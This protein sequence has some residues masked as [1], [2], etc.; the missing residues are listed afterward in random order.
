[1]CASVDSSLLW[2]LAGRCSPLA[3]APSPMCCGTRCASCPQTQ[4]PPAKQNCRTA[5]NSRC[6]GA[7]PYSCILPPV[8]MCWGSLPRCKARTASAST[9]GSAN[10][11][12]PQCQAGGD[13]C[14]QGRA[15]SGSMSGCST[16][17]GGAPRPRL[18]FRT[19]TRRTG[20]TT[21]PVLWTGTSL[22]HCCPCFCARP[23]MVH[24]SMSWQ[25]VSR[26]TSEAHAAPAGTW[27]HGQ[28]RN[29]MAWGPGRIMSILRETSS[30]P[31][32]S[33]WPAGESREGLPAIWPAWRG[34]CCLTMAWKL[35]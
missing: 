14:A 17:D 3:I 30:V 27:F 13:G 1:M 23:H 31:P 21:R 12:W 18:G 24:A 20:A 5:V 19:L 26:C 32:P 15:T 16:R 29:G 35:A 28:P 2:L 34:S 22:R 33:Q 6:A 25:V 10:V 8:S 4:V 7:Q 9:H 11:G